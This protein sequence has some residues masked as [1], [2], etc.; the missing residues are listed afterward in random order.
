[1]HKAKVV[2]MT[3]YPE[4]DIRPLMEAAPPELSVYY[5][6]NSLPV[7]TKIPLVCDADFMLLYPGDLSVDLAKACR[8][9]KLVQLFAAGY[10]RM[11]IKALSRLGIPVAN[12]GGS[13]ATAVAEFAVMLMLNVYKCFLPIAKSMGE[14]QWSKQ[15]WRSSYD[16]EGKTVGIV[17]LGNIG[18]KVAARLRGFEVKLLGYNSSA[19]PERLVKEL[20]IRM[21]TFEELL[22][23]SDIVTLHVPLTLKTSGFMGKRELAKMKK[24]A[25]L[26]N[27]SRGAVVDE[28]ALYEA[29]RTKKIAG[30]GLDVLQ[31]EPIAPDNPLSNLDNVIITP[32][33]AY[34]TLDSRMQCALFAYGNMK[35][36]LRGEE[37]L[38]VIKA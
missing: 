17:G 18:R 23:D 20:G 32:H 4:D 13:N 10:E 12:N 31:R 1:M 22:G 24:S 37:P 30:A 15:F 21:V 27:T 26:I 6:N 38:A 35:R 2:F 28:T 19:A 11:D 36:V 14:G 34:N 16:L 3:P 9:L 33:V 25:I 29:L 8:N 7:E 5:V